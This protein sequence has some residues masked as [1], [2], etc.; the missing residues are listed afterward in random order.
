MKIYNAIATI[1]LALLASCVAQGPTMTPLEIQSLQ[2][3]EYEQKKDVV[4]PSV[5]SVFQ[6][7]GYTVTSASKD[8]GLITAEGV[9]NSNAASKFWFGVTDVSQTKATAFIE[10]IG[11]ITKVRI[12]LV[13]TSKTSSRYGQND[14]QDTPILDATVYQNAFEKIENAI[15]VRSNS[16][17]E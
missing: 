9:T 11:R 15:F 1:L 3:R 8:T 5:I 2:T 10:Q 13:N 7:L 6:D 17:K 16:Y 4:F 14:Q 12:N